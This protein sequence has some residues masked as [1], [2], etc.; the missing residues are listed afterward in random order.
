[1]SKTTTC[2]ICGEPFG[3]NGLRAKHTKLEHPD[4]YHP[5]SGRR[6]KQ[7]AIADIALKYGKRDIEG[8]PWYR[9]KEVKP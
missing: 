1:M 3:N 9:T 5:T 6:T 2:N 8:K 4:Y 7:Q